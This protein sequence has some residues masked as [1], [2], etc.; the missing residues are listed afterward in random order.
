M[1]H[2]SI[3]Q[4]YGDTICFLFFT[5]DLLERGA[6]PVIAGISLNLAGILPLQK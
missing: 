4:K 2:I 3:C 6:L 1:R 5:Q